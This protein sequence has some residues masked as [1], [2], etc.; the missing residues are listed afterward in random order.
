MWD[1]HAA[2]RPMGLTSFHQPYDPSLPSLLMIHG[3]GGVKA[4]YQPLAAQLKGAVNPAA[5]D[6]PGH[7]DTPAPAPVDDVATYAAFVADFLAAGPVR[8]VLLGHS[9]GG[10][11]ALSVALDHPELLRG[12]IL[13]GSGSR[14][15]VLPAVLEGLAHNFLAT[16]E[17]FLKA[18]YAP[19]VDARTLELGARMLQDAGAGV[20]LGDLTAC[21]RFDVSA[22]LGEIRL[23]AL[24]LAGEL[25]ALT[26]PKYAQFL[27]SHIPGAREAVIP[28]AGHMVIL[29]QPGPA[30][31]AILDFMAIL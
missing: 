26:P 19:G 18:S 28:G 25:D 7:G 14:L 15:R 9:L 23:P 24:A 11:V 5:L 29:E 30:A 16:T 3:S 27:A 12:I 22:R 6:L 1:K 2:G 31:S 17:M 13:V 4:L 8:P 20:V 21:D 10:A